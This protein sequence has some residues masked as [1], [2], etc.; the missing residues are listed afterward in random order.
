MSKVTKRLPEAE[1]VARLVVAQNGL[2]K[3]LHEYQELSKEF[4]DGE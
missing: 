1:D 2:E 3:M 4:E